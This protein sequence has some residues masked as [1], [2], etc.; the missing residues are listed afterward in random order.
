MVKAWTIFCNDDYS[1]YTVYLIVTNLI[2]IGQCTTD[3][4]IKPINRPIKRYRPINRFCLS[5]K[6]Q[7]QIGIGSADYKDLY[8]L[9]GSTYCSPLLGIKMCL[10]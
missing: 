7:Y 10:K 5:Q 6:S 1:Y 4:P 8:R 9:I 2:S 3:L